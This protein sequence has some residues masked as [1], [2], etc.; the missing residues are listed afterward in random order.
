LSFL[1]V[2]AL[3]SS[4]LLPR[5]PAAPCTTPQSHDSLQESS[6]ADQY[7]I[8]AMNSLF[9]MLERSFNLKAEAPRA[10]NSDLVWS[11]NLKEA[12]AQRGKTREAAAKQRMQEMEQAEKD[13]LKTV[14]E[15]FDESE[16]GT[17]LD[18]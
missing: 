14:Q 2:V 18:D 11:S 1:F 13:L 4:C 9:D 12:I 15:T 10:D 7:A 5:P 3:L 16:E 17:G 8:K 6:V